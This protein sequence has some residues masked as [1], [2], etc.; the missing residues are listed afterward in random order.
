MTTRRVMYSVLLASYG[1]AIVIAQPGPPQP[2][3]PITEAPPG[4]W[5]YCVT[6]ANWNVR[7]IPGSILG[8]NGSGT[9]QVTIPAQGPIPWSE[10]RHGEGDISPLVGI[11]DAAAGAPPAGYVNNFRAL[12]GPQTHG[13]RVNTQ[14][15]LAFATVRR[16]GYDNLDTLDGIVPVGTVRG[17]AQFTDFSIGY[18]YSM[19]DGAWTDGGTGASDIN[20]GILGGATESSFNIATTYLPFQQGWSGGWVSQQ[21]ATGGAGVWTGD[22]GAS[23]DLLSRPDVVH[24]LADGRARIDL[25]GTQTPD[26]GYLFLNTSD[27]DN[28]M[29]IV[30]AAA[31]AG[32]WDVTIREDDSLDTTG[33]SGFAMQADSEF[34]FTYL[35]HGLP[36][37]IAGHI[38]GSTAAKVLADGAYSISRLGTGRYELTIPGKTEDDGMLLLS[39]AGL[40]PDL[41]PGDPRLSD[42]ATLSYEYNP[43]TGKWLIESVELIPGGNA[44][45]EA[46]QL[47]DMD[48]VFAYIDFTNPM[49]PRLPGDAN[50]DATVTGADFTVWADHFGETGVGVNQG[51]FT[52]DGKV[53]GASFTIWADNFGRSLS[54]LVP[55][56]EPSSSDLTLGA[57]ASMSVLACLVASAR[58][59]ARIGR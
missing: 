42:R 40:L 19:V 35:P 11:A 30:N 58:L 15:G 56:P 4:A 17:L 52:C 33:L 27:G 14:R 47:K 53:T 49:A 57:M 31:N 37:T 5:P 13:W 3:V 20:M 51:S 48:F 45:G 38:R 44:F 21:V 29:R 6:S 43:A 34:H 1:F 9:L 28:N 25:G 24:W 59:R 16:N 18:G 39:G 36:N 8:G 2:A 50:R 12:S 26:R 32:G 7:P 54:P 23:P 22:H 46:Y 10:S 55:T 41:Q